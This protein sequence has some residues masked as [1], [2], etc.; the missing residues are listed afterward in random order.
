MIPAAERT[1]LENYIMQCDRHG[2]TL[3][4]K[5]TQSKQGLK[6]VTDRT[7]ELIKEFPDFT[8]SNCLG[9]IEMELQEI[10]D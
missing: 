7:I 9:Q 4:C 6:Y 8:I 10:F 1:E 2:L 3:I 5:K